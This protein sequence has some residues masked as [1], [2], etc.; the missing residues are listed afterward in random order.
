MRARLLIVS[1]LLLLLYPPPAVQAQAMVN[2]DI[3]LIGDMRYIYRNDVAAALADQNNLAFEFDELELNIVGYLNP[4]ARADATLSIEGTSGPVNI[5]EGFATLLRGLPVQLKFGKYFLDFGRV[6][7]MHIHQMPWLEYPLENQ[8]F[9][10]PEGAQVVGV[11][12]SRLQ[13]IGDNAV[14]FSVNA[15]GS[16]IFG[17]EE[18]ENSDA[19]GSGETKI[20]G[21]A[22]VSV[23]REVGET[24]AIEIGGSYLNAAYDFAQ[25]LTTQVG[26]VDFTYKWTPGIY[27]SVKVIAEAMVDDREVETDTLGTV[28]NV[29]AYGAF[30]AAQ[31]KFR[32]VWNVGAFFD[33][34]ED[35]YVSADEVTSFG[36]YVMLMPVEETIIFNLVYRYFDSNVVEGQG[37][38]VTLQ[39][40]FGLGPHK[41]HPF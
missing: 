40:L 9:F 37:D 41:P 34:S 7:Q 20:G 38:T 24:S 15:F 36:G 25:D 23:F 39:V 31:V 10:G 4:Y 18:E 28:E 6:N 13:G 26:G 22:R 11:Q 16:D 1:C 29:T 33:W 30:A 14:R 35:A 3:S 5:E 19:E 27:H 2:P 21:S 32:Q 17:D 12:A 8:S